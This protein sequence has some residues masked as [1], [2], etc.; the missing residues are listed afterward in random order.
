MGN[1]ID[2]LAQQGDQVSVAGRLNILSTDTVDKPGIC[3][4]VPS[5]AV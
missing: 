1:P 4:G 5:L 3:G 2:S